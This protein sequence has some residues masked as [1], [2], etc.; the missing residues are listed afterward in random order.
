MRVFNRLVMVVLALLL[1][2][3]GLWALAISIVHALGIG[4]R[5]DWLRYFDQ[6]LHQALKTL[7]TLQLADWRVLASAAALIVL[8][9]LLLL[10][11]LRP[12]PPLIVFLDED[13]TASWWLHRAAFEG[14]LGSLLIKETT[15]VGVRARLRGRRSWRLR[16]DAA[17]SPRMRGE[18]EQLVHSSLERLGRAD[19]SAIRVSIHEA[20][21]A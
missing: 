3:A 21:V 9:L 8:G 14:M 12:W 10:L 11:E 2:V 15:A 17:G 13:D 20:R 18:V 4:W 19:D 6:S 5:P 7:S 1:V 16:V